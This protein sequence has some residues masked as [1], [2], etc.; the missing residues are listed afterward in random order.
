MFL[1]IMGL[2]MNITLTLGLPASEEDIE[3]KVIHVLVLW[4]TESRQT[5]SV[6]F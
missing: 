5:V 1:L 4:V 3:C 2:I 6:L